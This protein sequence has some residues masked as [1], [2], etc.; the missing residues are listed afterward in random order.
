MT[1]FK[2][3]GWLLVALALAGLAFAAPAVS[4]HGNVTSGDSVSAADGV[5]PSDATADDWAVWMEAQMTEH[6]GP[7]GVEWMES[8][9]GVTVDEMARNMADDD[10]RSGTRGQSSTYGHGEGYGQSGTYGHGGG[11]G[12]SG[13]YGHGGGY[14][15]SGTYGHGGGYGQ[16]HC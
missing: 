12:Q 6:M 11:Y 9:A 16:G 8:N 5:P 7:D 14:G 15:Q 2:L 13:T 10:D 4:A 1:N 3:G